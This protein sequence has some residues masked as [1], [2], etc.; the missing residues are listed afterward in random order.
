MPN[1]KCSETLPYDIDPQPMKAAQGLLFL[2]WWEYIY[3]K[4]MGNSGRENDEARE[5]MI[6]DYIDEHDGFLALSGKEY[7]AAKVTN[8]S[9]HPYA[10][11]FSPISPQVVSLL[12]MTEL[13]YKTLQEWTRGCT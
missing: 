5:I 4:W 12:L 9:I 7:Q 6:S 1:W 13:L 11:E 10:R 2:S 8:P 3:F